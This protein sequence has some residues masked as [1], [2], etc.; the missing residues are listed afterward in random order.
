[1]LE[2]ALRGCGILVGFAPVDILTVKV[3]RHLEEMAGKIRAL[4]Q[5]KHLV[6]KGQPGHVALNHKAL[7]SKSQ[8]VLYRKI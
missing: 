2:E 4:I 3:H 6:P 1:M 8:A 5:V 7:W